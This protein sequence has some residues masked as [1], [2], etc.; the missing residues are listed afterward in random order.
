MNRDILLNSNH[1]ISVID[2]DLTLTDSKQ[3][4]TQKIKQTLWLIKGEWFL[5]NDVGIPYYEEIFGKNK[6]LSRIEILYIRALQNIPEV[7]EIEVFNIEQDNATHTLKI[8]FE[9]R[10]VDNNLIS[11]TL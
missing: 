9:V 11:I 3:L 5:N 8:N 1:D 2:F 10:D 6:D 4:T 7:A